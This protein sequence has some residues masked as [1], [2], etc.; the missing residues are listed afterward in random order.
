MEDVN[1]LVFEENL[2]NIIKLEKAIGVMYKE[3]EAMYD[4]HVI[5]KADT[6]KLLS[7]Q[8]NK[9]IRANRVLHSEII[10]VKAKIKR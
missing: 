7:D 5:L 6:Y 9:K 8:K 4:E 10:E 1:A 2:N 3:L